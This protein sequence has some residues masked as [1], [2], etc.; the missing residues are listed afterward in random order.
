[1][2]MFY[3]INTEKDRALISLS[4]KISITVLTVAS[5]TILA[6]CSTKPSPWA[7]TSST[8]WEISDAKS[9][10]ASSTDK[11][12]NES[13]Y[14]A[15]T[16]LSDTSVIEN[17]EIGSSDVSTVDNQTE[18]PMAMME[19]MAG[20]STGSIHMNSTAMDAT[21]ND[22]MGNAVVENATVTES[23]A[24]VATENTESEV[25]SSAAV[26]NTEP[27]MSNGSVVMVENGGISQ[28]PA[29]MYAVQVVASSSMDNLNIFIEQYSLSNRWIV[30][31]TVDG[32]KWF[33]LMTGLY[34]SK[35]EADAALTELQDL[36]THPW[37]RTVGSVQVVMN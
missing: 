29:G 18:S 6:G 19:P 25:M 10:A 33:I 21:T 32:K 15:E 34:D 8:P 14:P 36:G 37:I 24:L 1:M 2:N 3:N 26:E 28:Q 20:E 9:S 27:S 7:E 11:P 13:D 30:E 17:E 4:E 35:E 12:E 31:T 22:Q 23:D 16:K 5:I